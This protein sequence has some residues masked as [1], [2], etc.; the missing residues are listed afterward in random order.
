MKLL[1][2]GESLSNTPLNNVITYFSFY[3]TSL[4]IDIL[5]IPVRQMEVIMSIV[6]KSIHKVIITFRKK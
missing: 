3:H 5:L 1:F 2:G 4:L 6:N